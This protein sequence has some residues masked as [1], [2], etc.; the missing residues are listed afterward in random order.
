M[1]F[2]IVVRFIALSFTLAT[3]V[4]VVNFAALSGKKSVDRIAPGGFGT[5]RAWLIDAHGKIESANN[6]L[7]L[8]K[9]WESFKRPAGPT[10]PT[11]SLGERPGHI[12]V[13]VPL[14]TSY[15]VLHRVPP[16]FPTMLGS[17]LLFNLPIIVIS[18]L[19]V[20]GV[21]FWFGHQKGKVARSV[22]TRLK[23]GDLKARFPVR[24]LD[25]LG[26]LM[27]TFNA[28]ADEIEHLVLKLKNAENAR[29]DLLRGLAHDLRTPLTAVS[30]HVE[31]V[32]GGATSF[33]RRAISRKMRLAHSEL[34]YFKRLLE[35][36]LILANLE[37]PQ[38]ISSE[39]QNFTPRDPVAREMVQ[40]EQSLREVGEKIAFVLKMEKD[41][42]SEVSA[43]P[44][45]FRRMIRNILENAKAFAKHKVQVTIDSAGSDSIRI[46][47]RDDG[48]GFSD[49]V[50]KS[51]GVHSRGS[52]YDSLARGRSSLGLGS[53]IVNKIAS[54]L[55][56]QVAAKNWMKRTGV[57]GG[58]EI[59]IILPAVTP[60]RSCDPSDLKKAA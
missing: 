37:D 57:R 25:E 20:A 49:E 21:V 6:E 41:E 53:V 48:P 30:L 56:G 23:S 2:H 46:R 26:R 58:A 39:K 29:R 45:L 60:S 50:L 17:L 38:F 44:Y 35:D 11:V 22:M 34:S 33:S 14:G 5:L 59:E 1:K 51:F 55:G 32:A 3:V 54:H 7:P 4:V 52:F 10:L 16:A 42:L 47:V 8:P 31:S 28:M 18:V 43:D 12:Y 19:L 9:R 24:K 40:L 13:V 36:L 15:L 27:A